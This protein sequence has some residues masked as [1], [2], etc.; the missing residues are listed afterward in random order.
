[1]F[2][3]ADRAARG[4]LSG[5]DAGTAVVAIL[6]IRPGAS[7]WTCIHAGVCVHPENA[8]ER[9]GILGA[10]NSEPVPAWDGERH[11]RVESADGFPRLATGAGVVTECGFRWREDRACL[12]RVRR[13][14]VD[15]H[16]EPVARVATAMIARAASEMYGERRNPGWLTERETEVLD[17]LIEGYT[18]GEIAANLH[19]SPHTVHDHVKSL[20]RKVGVD[21]R[22]D[23]VR[24]AMGGRSA[25]RSAPPRTAL[26]V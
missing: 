21:S 16:D 9:D 3:W 8:G 22:A 15:V 19:R 6:D 20:Y 13:D 12:V 17:L 1:M 5:D 11:L 14:T 25:A 4:L 7:L 23:V 24:A 10:I 18:V 2:D 26:A